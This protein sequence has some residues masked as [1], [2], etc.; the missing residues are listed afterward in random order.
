MPTAHT[1][2]S[3]R[4]PNSEKLKIGLNI[5]P[6][7][8]ELLESA[9]RHSEVIIFTASTKVYADAVLDFLDP[10]HEFIHHRL[11]R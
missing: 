11:Y 5:R 2:I 3:I 10:F 9:S 6:G 8:R 7:A 4:L 1:K